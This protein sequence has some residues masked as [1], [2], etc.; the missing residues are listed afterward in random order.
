MLLHQGITL[1][2]TTHG[3]TEKGAT[4]EDT[5]KILQKMCHVYYKMKD[6]TA[7]NELKQVE[8]VLFGDRVNRTK[9]NQA[10]MCTLCSGTE[11]SHVAGEQGMGRK[12]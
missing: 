10:W 7:F 11:K 8:R 6:E 5:G 9:T 2:T 12:G 3:H 4:P 1:G